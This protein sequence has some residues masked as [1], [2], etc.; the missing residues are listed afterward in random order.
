MTPHPQRI[1]RIRTQQ[2]PLPVSEVKILHQ[3]RYHRV[4]SFVPVS[5]LRQRSLL[6]VV[7][8]LVPASNTPTRAP[9]PAQQFNKARGLPSPST[10]GTGYRQLQHQQTTAQNNSPGAKAIPAW[11]RWTNTGMGPRRLLRQ[12]EVPAAAACLRITP[13]GRWEVQTPRFPSG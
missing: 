11:T 12:W 8:P 2:H 3:F 1:K 4:T 7:R 6:R 13:G 10:H 9:A 5:N